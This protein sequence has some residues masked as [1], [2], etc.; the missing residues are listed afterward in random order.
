[1]QTTTKTRRRNGC[2]Y[3]L[4]SLQFWLALEYITAW[5]MKMDEWLS[6]FPW[7]LI[8]YLV[9]ISIFLACLYG[10]RCSEKK[11][12]AVMLAV[13]Y[14]LELVA[15]QKQ[16]LLNPVLFVPFSLLLISIWGFLTFVPYWMV[17]RTIRER[18]TQT[19]AFCLWM[20]VALG[21]LIAS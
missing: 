2:F 11:T 7:V 10:F 17:E 6:L 21:F 4:L 1:M 14:F 16:E 3:V 20:L 13:M 18:K 5:H 8:Q 12:F 15:W 19:A 9:I